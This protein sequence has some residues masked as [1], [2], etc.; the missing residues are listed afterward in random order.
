M[1][2]LIVA[3]L[4]QFGH[5]LNDVMVVFLVSTKQRKLGSHLFPLTST[6]PHASIQQRLNY[7]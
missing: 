1:Q 5:Q 3:D 7:F 2:L 4:W 6:P